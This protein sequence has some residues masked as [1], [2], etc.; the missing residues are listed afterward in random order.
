MPGLGGAAVRGRLAADGPVMNA[1]VFR[2]V[3]LE[4]LRPVLHFPWRWVVCFAAKAAR[5]HGFVRQRSLQVRIV[6]INT[7]HRLEGRLLQAVQPLVRGAGVSP[8]TQM[9]ATY[10][11][12]CSPIR[13]PSEGVRLPVCWGQVASVTVLGANSP[14]APAIKPMMACASGASGASMSLHLLPLAEGIKELVGHVRASCFSGCIPR[15]R[16]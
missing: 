11:G 9:L 7:I 14:G 3:E 8:K 6:Q 1:A 16:H 12:C 4:R 10:Q 13:E 2:D 5:C 15:R